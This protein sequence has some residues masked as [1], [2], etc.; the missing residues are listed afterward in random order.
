MRGDNAD[1]LNIMEY[2]SYHMY[3]KMGNAS[4]K[5]FVEFMTANYTQVPEYATTSNQ[6]STYGLRLDILT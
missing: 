4:E 6:S 2:I 3:D 5:F 1:I